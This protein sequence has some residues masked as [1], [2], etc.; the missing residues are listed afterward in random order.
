MH[1]KATTIYLSFLMF[2]FI[3]HAVFCRTLAVV[4]FAQICPTPEKTLL[5]P[6]SRKCFPYWRKIFACPAASVLFVH[7][8]AKRQQKIVKFLLQ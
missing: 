4:L 3:F 1:R 6:P 8:N 7:M 5:F 2:L